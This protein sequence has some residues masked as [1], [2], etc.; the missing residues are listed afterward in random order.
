MID[1]LKQPGVKRIILFG[2]QAAGT[3]HAKSDTDLAVEFD[4]ITPKEA[5]LWRIKMLA[6]LPKNV[7]LVVYN[8]LPEELKRQVDKGKVLFNVR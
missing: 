4:S 5:T 8:V 6:K 3:A 7:D 2:S 1:V